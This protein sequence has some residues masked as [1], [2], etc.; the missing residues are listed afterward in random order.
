VTDSHHISFTL[1]AKLGDDELSPESIPFARL[2]LFNQQVETFLAGH[3][4]DYQSDELK[5]KIENGSYKLLVWLPA[6]LLPNLQQDLTALQSGASLD[7]I[8][9]KRATILNQWQETSITEPN[10]SFEITP[11]WS[12]AAEPIRI[13]HDSSFTLPEDK[14]LWFETEKYIKGEILEAGGSTRTN[15]H[16]KVEEQSR[17]ITIG[18]SKSSLKGQPLGRLYEEQVIRIKAEENY[19]T[20]ELRNLEFIEFVDYQPAFDSDE[21]D[22][23]IEQASPKWADVPDTNAWLDQIRNDAN[24]S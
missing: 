4:R 3:S 5:V 20:G 23:L 6:T 1:H 11:A 19:R 17:S 10:T 15:L 22:A 21:L 16:L 18:A 12:P 7:A 14:T 8:D 24:E 13:D 9:S 2:N